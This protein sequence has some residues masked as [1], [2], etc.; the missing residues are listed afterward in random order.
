MR[1]RICRDHR[2]DSLEWGPFEGLGPDVVEGI[3]HIKAMGGPR[4]IL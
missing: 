2:P 3:R 4:L 1:P